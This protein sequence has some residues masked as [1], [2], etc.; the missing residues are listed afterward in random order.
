MKFNIWLYDAYACMSAAF[1]FTEKFS[2]E[3][4]ILH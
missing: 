1:I 3:N 4:V 2:D